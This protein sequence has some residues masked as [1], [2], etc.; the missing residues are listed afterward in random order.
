MADF[1]MNKEG[2]IA[3][4]NGPVMTIRID[5]PQDKNGTDW[6]AMEALSEAY[7]YVADDPDVRVIV[8]TGTGDYFY[9]GG[10]VN[11]DDPEDR[12]NY[13]DTIARSG[14]VRRRVKLPT[15]AAVNGDC[16]KAGM[17][18]LMEADLAV[19]RKGVR[20][21]FPEMRMGG[22]PMMVMASCMD[23]PKKLALEAYYSSETFDTD[24]A[25]RLGLINC[26]VEE[27]DFWPTVDR[28]IHMIIDNPPALIQMTHD[29]YCAMAEMPT[30][31]ER[32]AYAHEM[33]ANKV[34]PQMAR[35]KT[36]YNV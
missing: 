6:R 26:A 9:T 28:Y 24:T 29:A 31:A 15:I 22:V 23:I 8:L 25:L 2:I 18:W 10:R 20:F 34:L 35:E 3:T 36:Q 14:P 19:A 30:K 21:G 13:A 12:K 4:V 32:T 7:A 16:L 11:A 5:R 1:S 27:E 33:L 17:G